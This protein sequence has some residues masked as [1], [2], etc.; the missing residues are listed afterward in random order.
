MCQIVEVLMLLIVCANFACAEAFA[1]KVCWVVCTAHMLQCQIAS[2]HV[3]LE[4]EP[5]EPYV[6]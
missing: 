2:A 3:V 6:S 1:E 4:E 5:V